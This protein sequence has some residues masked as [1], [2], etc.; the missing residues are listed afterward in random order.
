MQKIISNYICVTEYVGTINIFLAKF[1]VSSYRVM[2][3]LF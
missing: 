3:D 2:N 1:R